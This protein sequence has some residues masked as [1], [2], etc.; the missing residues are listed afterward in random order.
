MRDGK[1]LAVVL[2][3]TLAGLALVE[4][5]LRRFTRF[6]PGSDALTAP[7]ALPV[8]SSEMAR[9]QFYVQRLAAADGTDRAWFGQSPSALPNRTAPTAEMAAR[10]AEFERRGLFASQS[11][12]VWNRWAVERDRC[13]PHGL[14]RGFP[15]TVPTFT[16]S[17]RALHPPYRFPP[18]A[19]LPSGLVTNAFGLR[20]HPI[21]LAKPAKTVRI[22]FLG[23]STTV[24]YHP[25]AYSYPE[26]VEFWLNRLAEANHYD[27]RFEALNG[28]R[29]GIN[30][31]DIAAIAREELLPLDPD[32][33]VYYEGSNQFPAANRLVSPAIA[34]RSEIDPR[35]PAAGHVLPLAWRRHLAIANLV[36]RALM[37]SRVVGEPVKPSYRLLWPDGVDERNPDPDSPDLPLQLPAIVKD[38]DSIR[39]SLNSV[40]APLF[41]CSFDWFTPPG[42][43]LSG[44]RHRLVYRQLNTTLWPLRY[45]DIRRLADF[46]NRVFHNYAAA[47]KIGYLDVAAIF[48]KDADLQEDAIHPTEVGDRLR[49]WI[50]FQQ[51]V[52]AVRALLES[53]RLPRAAAPGLPP[54]PAWA[55]AEMPTAC[56]PPGGPLRRLTGLSL[57]EIVPDPGS[58]Y[59]V[60]A[61]RF[62]RITTGPEQW[63]YAARFPLRPA[64][65]EAGALW[66]RLR[67]RVLHGQI[68]FGV[69]DQVSQDFQVEKLVDP[70]AGMQDVYLPVPDPARAAMLVV[71]NTAAGGVQSTVVIEEASLVSTP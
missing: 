48:P 71:R 57:D 45:A 40:G 27:V 28:G 11:E 59:T 46:Q 60:D 70:T 61:Q 53:H 14:F 30:S 37:G 6:A 10:Y 33:A 2:V 64:A 18:N 1:N 56:A 12:Y 67:V 58:T 22:A 68:G 41:L 20:G 32:L 16:P 47:R 24:G 15:D 39:A 36:D 50:F 54:F 63:A 7:A 44:D 34:P 25:F 66:I 21:A 52:P 19:T 17:Q 13:N 49:A 43:G 4:T 69:Q 3:A 9:A 8:A 38:L 65:G 29:E 23:A 42:E 55:P 62:V 5:G 31:S 35:A 26:Y 51:L